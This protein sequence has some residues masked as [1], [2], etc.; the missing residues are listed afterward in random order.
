MKASTQIKLLVKGKKRSHNGNRNLNCF[1]S[2]LSSWNCWC[3]G[4]G[5][6]YKA[7]SNCLTLQRHSWICWYCYRV[8]L[9]RLISV[10]LIEPLIHRN[11]RL[12]YRRSIIKIIQKKSQ[13]FPQDC[14]W[15]LCLCWRTVTYGGVFTT[16]VFDPCVGHILAFVENKMSGSVN[17]KRKP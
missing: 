14:F 8:G 2:T 16:D 12:S 7:L 11:M 1:W 3:L 5:Y 4:H 15:G 6:P 13:D 9:G 10:C 17:A